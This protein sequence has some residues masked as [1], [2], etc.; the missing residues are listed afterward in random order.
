MLSLEFAVAICVGDADLWGRMGMGVQGEAGGRYLMLVAGNAICDHMCLK[1][2]LCNYVEGWT[3]FA[4]E[5]DLVIIRVIR[6]MELLRIS[7]RPA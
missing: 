5:S 1:T 2:S 6:A 4:F 3:T 7:S